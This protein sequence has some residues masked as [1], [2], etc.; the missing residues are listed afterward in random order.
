MVWMESLAGEGL[1]SPRITVPP[2]ACI[3]A[4]VG[5]R[6]RTLVTWPTSRRRTE[7]RPTQAAIEFAREMYGPLAAAGWRGLARYSKAD[8]ELLID[9]LRRT[10]EVQETH[11]RR[12]RG[13]LKR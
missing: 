5:D 9:V 6:N 8:L 4:T 12:L 2:V 7:V 1:V 3:R 11:T 10:R 13:K